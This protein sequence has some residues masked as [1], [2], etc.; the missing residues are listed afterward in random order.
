MTCLD[1]YIAFRFCSLIAKSME[2][3]KAKEDQRKADEEYE[4]MSK[5]KWALLE[6]R[7]KE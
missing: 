3:E 7:E 6:K 5:E 1:M 2:L 4:A